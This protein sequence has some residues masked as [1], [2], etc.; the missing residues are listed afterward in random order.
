MPHDPRVDRGS[1][2]FMVSGCGLLRFARWAL[3]EASA[4]ERLDSPVVG[5]GRWHRA[6]GED[7]FIAE[8]AD[9]EVAVVEAQHHT[10]ADRVTVVTDDHGHHRRAGTSTRQV[11]MAASGTLA[12]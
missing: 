3:S 9:N 6:D 8:R 2:V 7:P 5:G 11:R 10:G 4:Y 1:Q 12:R